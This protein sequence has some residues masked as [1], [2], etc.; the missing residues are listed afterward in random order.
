MISHR[1]QY[2]FSLILIRFAYFISLFL[3]IGP[4]EIYASVCTSL[5]YTSYIRSLSPDLWYFISRGLI[6]APSHLRHLRHST[7]SV[8]RAPDSESEVRRRTETDF[9]STLDQHR[10]SRTTPLDNSLSLSTTPPAFDSD[11]LFFRLP[12]S[13]TTTATRIRSFTRTSEVLLVVHTADLVAARKRRLINDETRILVVR[14]FEGQQLV[15]TTR[16]RRDVCGIVVHW[17]RNLCGKMK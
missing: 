2:S 9:L 1:F 6:S 7:P 13:T 8:A 17:W 5:F 15:V 10:W 11:S 12:R 14:A 4:L 16:L 3:I